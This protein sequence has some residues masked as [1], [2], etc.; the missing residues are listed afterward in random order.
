MHHIR[1]ETIESAGYIFVFTTL[2]RRFTPTTILELYRGRWQIEITFKRLKSIIGVGHLKKTDLEAA[3]SWIHGK[4]LVAFLIEALIVAA[5]RFFPW[6]YPIRQTHP[7][8]TMPLARDLVN[9][10][11]F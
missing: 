6:G 4:L 3:K 1:P 7:E 9:A 5:E 2:D 11:S 10:S 8:I